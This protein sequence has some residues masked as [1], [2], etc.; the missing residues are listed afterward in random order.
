M[1][2][3]G[4]TG[5][6][7]S[8]KSTLSA[9]AKERDVHV[10]DADLLGHKA[11]EPNTPCFKAV[12]EEFGDEIVAK[13]GSID[14]KALGS[15][16]FAEGSSLERLTDIVW[17]HIRLMAQD[18]IK[19]MQAKD[20]S[21]DVLLEAAVLIEAGWQDIVDEVWVVVVDENTAIDR[22]MQRDGLDRD[23]VKARIDAQISNEERIAHADV[24]I[25]NSSSEEELVTRIG[26]AFDALANRK[27]KIH[28][29]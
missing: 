23:A 7:A 13:D 8:G 9:Y 19:S 17:P 20:A 29:H 2:I 25:D 22:T 27:N 10:I 6:I 4:L 18:E 21:K 28:A 26:V 12:V 16:V 1:T 3:I 15:I 11:Y 14:R 24:V 5:G